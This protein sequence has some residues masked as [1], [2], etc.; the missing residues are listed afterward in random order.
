MLLLTCTCRPVVS[1]TEAIAVNQ[2]W[3]GS[4]GTLVKKW[5][6]QETNAS[7][8][9]YL[10]GAF[11]N[12]SAAAGY[13]WSV[14]ATTKQVR[15]TATTGALV[16]NHS[17]AAGVQT[18]EMCLQVGAG[19]SNIQVLP[20]NGTDD[21]LQQ[22][23]YDAESGHITIATP[24]HGG[25]KPCANCTC[26][27]LQEDYGLSYGGSL[28]YTG[29]CIPGRYHPDYRFNI[30]VDGKLVGDRSTCIVVKHGRSNQFGPVQLWTKPQTNGGI[31]VFIQNTGSTW[32]SEGQ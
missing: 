30:T 1:N 7:A 12:D 18:A 29:G 5:N 13:T 6:P 9:T 28:V 8:P 10:W 20:C 24:G 32:G 4:V 3:A 19:G 27:R 31:A 16:Y 15:A 22:A 21:P 26:M 23:L 2:N 25:T 14:D 11:C 17:R